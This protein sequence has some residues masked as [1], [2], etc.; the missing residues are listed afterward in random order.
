MLPL[1]IHVDVSNGF[2]SLLKQI[3]TVISEAFTHQAYPFDKLVED[4]GIQQSPDR[5]PLFDVAVVF[6][7]TNVTTVQDDDSNDLKITTLASEIDNSKFDMLWFFGEDSDNLILA[8]NYNTDLFKSTTIERI[9]NHYRSLLQVMVQKLS[10]P[11]KDIN[12]LDDIE[13]ATLNNAFAMG[14]SLQP[15]SRSLIDCFDEVTDFSAA[16]IAIFDDEKSTTYNQLKIQSDNLAR[17]LTNTLHIKQGDRV[18]IMMGRGE[19]LITSILAIIKVG[20]IYVPIDLEYP[21][22]RIS[23]IIE[24]ARIQLILTKSDT[25]NKQIQIQS[26]CFDVSEIWEMM[27]NHNHKFI[28]P[29]LTLDQPVY[30]MYTSGSTGKP[31][32][33]LVNHRSL[34][35]YIVWA[36]EYYFNNG[37]GHSF[38]F[39]TSIA[40]DLTNTSVF[41]TLLR[42]DRVKVFK[43]KHHISEVLVDIFKEESGVDVVKLTPSHITI[44][45]YL[46]LK[47]STVKKV[48]V[49]GEALSM[50]QVQT[51]KRLN[52]TIQIYNEYGPTEA[53]IGCTVSEIDL[54]DNITVGRPINNVTIR[55]LD[56][57]SKLVPQGV[58]G[59]LCVGGEC[60]SQ[61]YV[62]APE[63]THEKFFK[64]PYDSTKILYKTGDIAL[65]TPDGQIKLAG[66]NDSQIKIRGYRVE[67]E[68]IEREI[69]KVDAIVQNIVDLKN[70]S[71]PSELREK[72]E[73]CIR[74]GIPTNYPGL[75]MDI[76]GVC[77]ICH[78]YDNNK[79]K[80]NRYFRTEHELTDIFED[81]KKNG[82]GKY[83]CL[84]LYS[85]GKDS[86]YVLCKLVNDYK[87]NVLTYTLDNGFISDD[88]KSN[89]DKTI[90]KLGVDHIYGKTSHMNEIFVDS[91]K[92][93]KN[94]C[95]GCYKTLY[96]LSLNL[97]EEMGI[98]CIVTGLSR[99]QLFET[100]LHHLFKSDVFDP[101]RVD[102]QIKDARW[103]YHQ[104][105][106]ASTTLLNTE[107]FNDQTLLDR[108]QIVDFY[109]YTSVSLDEVYEYIGKVASWERPSD[110][111]RSTN[112]LINEL[113]I[114]VH[115]RERKHHNY[116]LPYSWDVRLGHKTRQEAIAE[117]NDNLEIK[118]INEK[119]VDIG[120]QDY[121]KE[122]SLDN[123]LVCYYVTSK[124]IDVEEIK[125]SIREQLTDYMVPQ[126]FVKMDQLP[127]NAH[128]KVDRSKLP[129]G[130]DLKELNKVEYV[131]PTTKVEEKLA[132]F[133]IEAL[134]LTNIG[135][136]DN[137]FELGGT[138]IKII[139]LHSLIQSEY[140]G[141]IRAGQ[142]F[143]YNTIKKQ[144]DLIE[145]SMDLAPSDDEDP[146][147]MV[148][149]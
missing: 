61:G 139:I 131:A 93:Y 142:L 75:K 111:G 125:R 50:G 16:S 98:S 1:R 30:I 103:T 107:I 74:C 134:K 27:K 144:A 23:W 58:C 32:G 133:W 123:L 85:G 17:Y 38:A 14:K 62:N 5:S 3:H 101:D 68:E 29:A 8:L 11:I 88:A 18:G 45:N 52:P 79:D 78:D 140:P 41:T 22:E 106:D 124:S 42:G 15:G 136:D 130:L 35:N 122:E 97:A 120:Y 36:N 145:Q 66:R 4:L 87:L 117:L 57:A 2:K 25:D 20:A 135:V 59:E 128:G 90:T 39:F 148:Q 33:V 47:K 104:F 149:F 100:R 65:W 116:A 49:G 40:F 10:S 143:D 7:N 105:E 70:F 71:D 37:K 82:K 146:I 53:T 83:D 64:D 119:L 127:I 43:D 54:Q 92:R 112:C 99:G 141:A 73:Y 21:E 91:L 95:D 96:T 86:T 81:A 6:Q 113:G 89:I 72:E 84:V 118:S 13:K 147:E 102:Q 51:L 129:V 26:Q 110:T 80:I 132:E 24:D 94:V 12:Y 138:S 115:R 28:T 69:N 67:L 31:K 108:I 63:K 19:E 56:N 34:L 44:L 9:L 109:R 55:I 76:D 137:F 48:I 121:L 77:S 114:Y 60:I 126:L 46:P